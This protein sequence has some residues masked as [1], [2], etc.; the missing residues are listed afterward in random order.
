MRSYISKRDKFEQI[1][2]DILQ[3]G[4]K[5]EDFRKEMNVNMTVRF[6]LGILNSL[7]VWYRE[8]GPLSPEEIT[9]EVLDFIAYSI[10]YDHCRSL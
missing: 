3:E 7:S 5:G 10:C 4:I 8:S 9:E 6:I 2:R 1:F